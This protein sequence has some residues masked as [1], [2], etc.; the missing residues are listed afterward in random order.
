[1]ITMMQ[2]ACLTLQRRKCTKNDWETK[3]YKRHK[4]AGMFQ[5]IKKF[6]PTA[7]FSY[8]IIYLDVPFLWTLCICVLVMH[9]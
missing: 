8:F 4:I 3:S 6:K 2:N 9:K 5:I 1:M 7:Y